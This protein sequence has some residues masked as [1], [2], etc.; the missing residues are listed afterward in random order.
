M[1]S[2]SWRK[3]YFQK[4]IEFSPGNNVLDAAA[5]THMVFFEVI[6]GV[7]STDLNRATWNNQS[8]PPP[9]KV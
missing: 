1:K 3:D 8:L 5:L 7:S 4:L 6:H 9:R 2:I